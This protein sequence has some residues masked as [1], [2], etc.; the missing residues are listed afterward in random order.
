MRVSAFT[1]SLRA[2]GPGAAWAMTVNASLVSSEARSTASGRARWSSWPSTEAS[3]RRTFRTISSWVS[4]SK[5]RWGTAAQATVL[6]DARDGNNRQRPDRPRRQWHRPRSRAADPRA[7]AHDPAP[8]AWPGRA[9]DR[10]LRRDPDTEHHLSPRLLA[11]RWGGWRG[12]QD[13][14]RS[15]GAGRAATTPGVGFGLLDVRGGVRDDQP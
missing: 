11:H 13:R 4:P 15:G 14:G 10:D 12:P 8:W 2:T 9:G 5:L 7:G 1:T 3:Q 6:P